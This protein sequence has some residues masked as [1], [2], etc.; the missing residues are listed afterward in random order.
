MGDIPD[1]QAFVRYTSAAGGYSLEV[2]EGWARNG[3]GAAITFTSTLNRVEIQAARGAAA[4]TTA[5]V[6]SGVL[7][8]LSKTDTSLKVTM[9]ITDC[10]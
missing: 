4:P 10:P 6:R 8:T 5:S 9:L 7:T 1:S 3:L 2:P